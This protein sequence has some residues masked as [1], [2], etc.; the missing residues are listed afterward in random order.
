MKTR[1]LKVTFWGREKGHNKRN[2]WLVIRE[3]ECPA[4]DVEKELAKDW[5]VD[6]VVRITDI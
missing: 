4:Q 3:L 6:R 5:E 1:K 2:K